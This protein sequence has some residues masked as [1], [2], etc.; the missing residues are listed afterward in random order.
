MHQPLA[1]KSFLQSQMF[2]INCVFFHWKISIL[3]THL[4]IIDY[5]SKNSIYNFYFFSIKKKEK[6]KY[7]RFLPKV[8]SICSRKKAGFD[9]KNNHYQSKSANFQLDIISKIHSKK[10][11]VMSYT[12]WKLGLNNVQLVK[13]NFM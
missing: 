6:I 5:N 11:V 3:Q 1:Y 9:D 12:S 8:V 13:K 2:K 4:L 10:P 7:V